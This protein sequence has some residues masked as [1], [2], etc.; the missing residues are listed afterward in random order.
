MSTGVLVMCFG[1]NAWV[2]VYDIMALLVYF[3]LGICSSL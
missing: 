1:I 2:G 3:G